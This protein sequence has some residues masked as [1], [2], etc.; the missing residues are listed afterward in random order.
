[1]RAQA[2]RRAGHQAGLSNPAH[3]PGVRPRGEGRG[4][5]G[6]LAPHR[7]PAARLRRAGNGSLVAGADLGAVPTNAACWPGRSACAP[8][9]SPRRTA[10]R[11]CLAVWRGS[12]RP[13]TRASSRCSAAA[14]RRMPG[15]RP[16]A[17]SAISR[18]SNP[19][20]ACATWCAPGPTCRRGWSKTCSGSAAIPNVRRQRAHVARCLLGRVVVAGAARRRPSSRHG[21]GPP[22]GVCPSRRG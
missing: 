5:G 20:S 13:A 22:S 21:P 11:S 1:M 2:F 10:I 16:T 8:T 6:N 3:G 17:R 18:C 15:C 4:A 9:R 19:R 14:P 7:G 12:A